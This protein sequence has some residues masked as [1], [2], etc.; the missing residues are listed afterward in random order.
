MTTNDLAIPMAGTV[1]P[2]VRDDRE[3]AR[4]IERAHRVQWIIIP[5]EGQAA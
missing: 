3:Y 5:D 1:D 2:R 4:K